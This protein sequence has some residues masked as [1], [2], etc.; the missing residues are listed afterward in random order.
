M[1]ILIVGPSWV[2][3][4]VI[5][6]SLFK[7][8]KSNNKDSKIEVIAPEWTKD[9]FDRMKEV[10]KTILLPFDHGEIKLK[11]R[12]QLGKSLE[13]SNYDQSIVLPNSFK[14]P[15][16]VPS[17]QLLFSLGCQLMSLLRLWWITMW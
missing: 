5:S 7:V 10:S 12:V 3:D 6:Q 4:S 14:C 15:E 2:G 11:D 8:I 13:N 1:K 9:I 16:L 17:C